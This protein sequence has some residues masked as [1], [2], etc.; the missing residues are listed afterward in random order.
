MSF[1]R[2][3]GYFI[4]III[5]I[6]GFIFLPL[7]LVAVIIGFIFIWMLRRGAKQEKIEKHLKEI[8]ERDKARSLRD[9]ADRDKL[10]DGSK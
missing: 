9:I 2:G 8:N 6:L 5:I 1:W 10:E 4:S 3:L 7:G